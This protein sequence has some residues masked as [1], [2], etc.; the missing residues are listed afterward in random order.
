MYKIIWFVVRCSANVR[1]W[2]AKCACA[3]ELLGQKGAL[4][5]ALDGGFVGV[6]ASLWGLE[7]YRFV[8]V[9]D[10]RGS[11]AEVRNVVVSM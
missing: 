1:S 7:V 3:R 4:A 6:E 9:M 10:S 2:A 11:I 5:A 8:V